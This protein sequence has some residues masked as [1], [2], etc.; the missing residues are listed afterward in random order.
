M[1]RPRHG[2][3]KVAALKQPLARQ[4][5]SD[6]GK[7]LAHWLSG[8]CLRI[9]PYLGMKTRQ[10]R[11]KVEFSCVQW[12]MRADIAAGAFSGGE[13]ILPMTLRE[14]FFS[15][16]GQVTSRSLRCSRIMACVVGGH[17]A[18]GILHDLPCEFSPVAMLCSQCRCICRMHHSKRGNSFLDNRDLNLLSRQ[19]G[20]PGPVAMGSAAP[21]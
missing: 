10:K 4:Q 2:V 9:Q 20:L 11:G 19:P 16:G 17:Q 6:A 8:K 1:T 3:W 21:A 14:C 7:V 18:R 15:C 13:I 12:S 5:G